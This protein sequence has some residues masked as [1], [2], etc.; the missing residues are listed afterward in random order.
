MEFDG[1][2]WFDECKF[3]VKEWNVIMKK[4]LGD[5]ISFFSLC[6]F[7]LSFVGGCNKLMLL[8]S[9]CKL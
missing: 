6:F 4:E 1:I 9:I 8:E 2:K 5:C 7:F 3:K